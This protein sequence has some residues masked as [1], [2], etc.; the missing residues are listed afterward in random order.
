MLAHLQ[1]TQW[2]MLEDNTKV[3][4]DAKYCITT[5]IYQYLSEPI[6]FSGEIGA[7]SHAK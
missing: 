1:T 3:R 2:T 7:F 4:Q 5:L 6:H